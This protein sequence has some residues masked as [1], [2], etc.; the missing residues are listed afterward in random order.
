MVDVAGVVAGEA[1]ERDERSSSR[2][3]ALVLE[4]APQELDLLP[5]AELRDGPVRL[6]PDA[7]VAI[8]RGV[9]DLLVPLRPQA[10]ASARSS[11][12]WARASAWAAASARLT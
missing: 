1:L 12:A 2:G 4:P 7:V 5:E 11:P 8:A 10:C 9:L 3:R 6:R